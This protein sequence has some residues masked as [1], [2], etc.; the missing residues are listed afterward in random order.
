[1]R[2]EDIPERKGSRN[3]CICLI[4]SMGGLCSHCVY[5]PHWSSVCSFDHAVWLPDNYCDWR[6]V[7]CSELD[8]Q[9]FCGEHD[10]ALFHLQPQVS[11]RLRIK[12][13]VLF[14]MGCH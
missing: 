4:V 11:V 3:E 5:F 8:S 13:Y 7:L 12:L 14:G 6:R 10:G 2:L 1:M 9:L